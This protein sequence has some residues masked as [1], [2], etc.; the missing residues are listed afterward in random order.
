MWW[1]WFSLGWAGQGI[2]PA[3]VE[4]LGAPTYL[5]PEY[6]WSAPVLDEKPG[7]VR[8][9]VHADVAA[10]EVRFVA[11]RGELGSAHELPLEGAVAVWNGLD[12]AVLRVG[13]LV[14]RVERPQGGA[15]D[16]A[17]RLLL[18][19]VQA[20][21]WP[22]APAPEVVEGRLVLGPGWRESRVR[23]AAEVQRTTDGRLLGLPKLAVRPEVRDEAGQLVL[24]SGESIELLVWDLFGR[25]HTVVVQAP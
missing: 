14:A 21:A 6:G 22:V 20:G 4:L 9:W 17:E 15:G 2:D 23:R 7:R 16:L 12:Q 13:D 25:G 1:W 19:V 5:A 24:R 8:V 3:A 18:G 11:L 10:A